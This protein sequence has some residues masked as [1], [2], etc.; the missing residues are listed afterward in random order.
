MR[1]PQPNPG[2]S[3][4]GRWRALISPRL[5]LIGFA[6][7]LSNG[8]LSIGGGILI[9]P[10]LIFLRRVSARVAVSTSLGT[11]LLMSVVA[12][13]AHVSISGF[14]MSIGGSALLIAAGM[15]SAQIGGY[16]LT[17]LPQRWV[18]FAFSG[19]TLIS[20]GHLI[21]VALDIAPPISSGTPPLWSYVVIGFVSGVFS[22]LLGVGGGGIAVLG[23]SVGF[24][25]PVLGGLPMALAMNVTNSLSG[26]LA[27][28]RS[29]NILWGDVFRIFPTTLPG[30]ALGV[31][32]AIYLPPDVLRIVFAL[33]F[34]FISGRMFHRGWRE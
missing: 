33:F 2:A 34:V 12:L 16:L 10:G 29:R 15:A 31:A 17:H 13:A 11:V 24:H 19:L 18:F 23:F 1:P 32:L 21:A 6:A 27:Q 30:I 7:G 22:G 25:T 9:V 20:G 3:S 5:A 4:Q 26:V 28:W 8:L 14:S